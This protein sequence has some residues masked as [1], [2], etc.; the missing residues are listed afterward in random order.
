MKKW[1]GILV[2]GTALLFILACE[3]AG[4]NEKK[5]P[6][7]PD[8]LE[9]AELTINEI[10]EPT[11]EYGIL[12]DSFD[13]KKDTVKINQTVSDILYAN[14]IAWP[15]INAISDISKDIF[16]ITRV[17]AGKKY[18]VIYSADTTEKAQ[19]F[20][21]E[22]DAVNYIVLDLNKMNV[23]TGEKQVQIKLKIVTNV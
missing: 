11:Y 12:M 5:P 16:D 23:Y 2:T 21:Y 20:I 7:T 9:A 8:T 13:V 18:S 17:N 14:H 6:T 19:Y 10:K 3:P 4:N 22:L 15:K 1:S